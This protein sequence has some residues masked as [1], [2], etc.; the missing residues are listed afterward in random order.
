MCCLVALVRLPW[1]RDA[2][3]PVVLVINT[4]L[5]IGGIYFLAAAVEKDFVRRVIVWI[6]ASLLPTAMGIS[7]LGMETSLLLFAV[8]L[9]LYEAGREDPS[10]LRV[11]SALLFLLPWIRVDAVAYCLILLTACALIRKKL[12]VLPIICLILGCLS[13]ATF[14]YFTVG[15]LINQTAIAK[16][17]AYHPD[18]SPVAIVGR[19]VDAFFTKSIFL[20]LGKESFRLA[21]I[22]FGSLT[23]AVLGYSLWHN[24]RDWPRLITFWLPGDLL[25]S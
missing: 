22:V 23:V 16:H 2:F 25:P 6:F 5:A 4:F 15:H 14:N 8:G 11:L 19:V 21:A 18:K 24:R 12:P 3:I 20:P 7:I 17:L 1:L 13:L 10:S 9:G